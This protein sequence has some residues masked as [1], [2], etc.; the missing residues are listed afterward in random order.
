MSPS[1]E[2]DELAGLADPSADELPPW[3]PAEFELILRKPVDSPDGKIA[4]IM[5]REPNGLEW[6]EIMA[7][8]TATRRRFGVSKIGGVPM[9]VCAQIGIGDLVRGE[10]Y[11][12][13]F[14][15]IGQVIGAK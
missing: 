6:E 11:L 8:P 4:S 5:L 10:A 12:T 3:P 14:F 1:P 13:S 9:K 2:D 15:D 7:T